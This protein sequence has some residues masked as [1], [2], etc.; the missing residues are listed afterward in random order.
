M[1]AGAQQF[2]P[3]LLARTDAFLAEI[4]ATVSSD[5]EPVVT[6]TETPVETPAAAA[7]ACSDAAPARDQEDGAPPAADD[8]VPRCTRRTRCPARHAAT[9]GAQQVIAQSTASEHVAEQIASGTIAANATPPNGAGIPS[10][11]EAV[12]P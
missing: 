6:E 1:K 10:E 4:S 8:Q 9:H 2:A 7:A 11:G 12:R 3:D 5:P